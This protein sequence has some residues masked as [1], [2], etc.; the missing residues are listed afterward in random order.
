MTPTKS[1]KLKLW[2][3]QKKVFSKADLFR[4][5][6]D[7]YYLR[8]WRSVCDFV[9][10]GLA[11]KLTDEECKIRGLTTAMAWYVWLGEQKEAGSTQSQY[12]IRERGQLAYLA[13]VR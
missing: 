5:G 7:N 9:V 6:I 2:C 3:A 1:D 13:G 12:Y 8:A 10:Q 4:Y 11:K